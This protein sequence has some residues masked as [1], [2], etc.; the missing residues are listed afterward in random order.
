VRAHARK[1]EDTNQPNPYV[2]RMPN[3]ADYLIAGAELEKAGLG[4]VHKNDDADARDYDRLF[5]L[6][7]RGFLLAVAL[8]LQHQFAKADN[9]EMVNVLLDAA[10]KV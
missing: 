10:R 1:F 7:R 4:K 2:S 3:D 6:T 9:G 8:N 5:A